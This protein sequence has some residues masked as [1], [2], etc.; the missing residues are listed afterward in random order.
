[1]FASAGDANDTVTTL[2]NEGFS[3][4]DIGFLE[5]ADLRRWKNPARRQVD[6]SVVSAIAAG[7]V[8][9]SMGAY[10]VGQASV[11]LAI[12]GAVTGIGIGAYVGA[13]L[14]GLF[15]GDE[16]VALGVPYFLRQVQVGRILVSA[17]VPDGDGEA[18]AAAVLHGSNALEVAIMEAAE[19]RARVHHPSFAT[20][21]DADEVAAA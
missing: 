15:V 4:R 9:G 3:S 6:W 12:L 10:L 7:V 13:V 14:G 17:E 21:P 18:R 2:R 1:L 11:A 5:P 19:L 16:D 8:G 20:E